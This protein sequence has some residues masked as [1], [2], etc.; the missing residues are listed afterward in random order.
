LRLVGYDMKLGASLENNGHTVVLSLTSRLKPYIF[1][2]RLPGTDR[3]EFLQCHWHWGSSS[4]Q[5][6]EHKLEGEALPME[7]HLVHWNTKYK[8]VEEAVDKKDG[9]AVVAFLYQIQEEDNDSLSEIVSHLTNLTDPHQSRSTS[10]P[11]SL[12]LSSL[13][14]DT[15]GKG[16]YFYYQG[17]LTTPTC[18]ESVLWTVFRSPMG[19][20]EQQLSVFRKIQGFEGENLSNNFRYDQ[21]V[22]ERKVYLRRVEEQHQISAEVGPVAAVL[23]TVTMALL[24]GVLYVSMLTL[25]DNPVRRAWELEEL[26]F[27]TNVHKM[28]NKYGWNK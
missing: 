20:S 1:G 4:I 19:V 10:S 7:L 18:D 2:G 8:E 24:A 27:A 17:S 3:F 28:I 21:P 13:L 16:S 26:I 22:G 6:S 14:P 15:K 9:L 5:G 25:M 23:V 11:M 12:T